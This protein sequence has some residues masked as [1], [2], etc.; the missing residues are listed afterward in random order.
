MVAKIEILYNIG[1]APSIFLSGHVITQDQGQRYTCD[2][3]NNEPSSK[4]VPADEIKIGDE[5]TGA[6]ISEDWGSSLG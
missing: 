1:G 3:I 2:E 4:V 6:K 5:V